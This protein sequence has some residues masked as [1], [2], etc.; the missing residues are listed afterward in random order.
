MPVL[1]VLNYH[2]TKIFFKLSVF[3]LSRL[4]NLEYGFKA[5]CILWD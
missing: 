3:H 4:G 1:C 5:G 2:S